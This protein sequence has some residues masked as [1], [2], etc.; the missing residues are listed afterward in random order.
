MGVRE[1]RGLIIVDKKSLRVYD[2]IRHA[3]S[4]VGISR[5]LLLSKLKTGND[6]DFEYFTRAKYVNDDSESNFVGSKKYV[7]LRKDK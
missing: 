7:K 4:S 5:E 1:S 3:T 6:D 2:S